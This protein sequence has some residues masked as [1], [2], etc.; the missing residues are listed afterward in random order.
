MNAQSGDSSV[1]QKIRI[2]SIDFKIQI[3]VQKHTYLFLKKK[4]YPQKAHDCQPLPMLMKTSEEEEE[5]E[6]EK[7]Q[8]E[9]SQKLEL[10]I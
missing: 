10:L 8:R 4:K 2:A 7:P 3:C 1:Q 6:E 9:K 5:E